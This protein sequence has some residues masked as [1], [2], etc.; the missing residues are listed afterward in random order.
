MTMMTMITIII[1]MCYL[2]NTFY[3]LLFDVGHMSKDHLENKGETRCRHSL[4]END[5]HSRAYHTS[6]SYIFI[7]NCMRLPFSDTQ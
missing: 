6:L 5:V 7:T 2:V 4:S 1:K 3:L